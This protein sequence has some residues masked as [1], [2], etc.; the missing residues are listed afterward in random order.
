LGFYSC[1]SPPERGFDAGMFDVDHAD[2][3]DRILAAQAI[4]HNLPVLSVD[5]KLDLFPIMHIW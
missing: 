1:L 5:T 3:W 2:P 4:L